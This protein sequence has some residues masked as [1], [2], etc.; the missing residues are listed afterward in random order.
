MRNKE[1]GETIDKLIELAESLKTPTY[2]LPLERYNKLYHIFSHQ[3]IRSIEQNRI[4]TTI[5]FKIRNTE[6]FIIFN[7][8]EWHLVGM[9][10]DGDKVD[11]LVDNKE[12]EPCPVEREDDFLI[13]D[14]I[15]KKIIGSKYQIKDFQY[16]AL[17]YPIL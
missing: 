13:K 7:N 2:Q 1:R 10:W 9:R 3:L 6:E 4:P 12:A 15:E 5:S 17:R 16:I 11:F 14:Y 8:D